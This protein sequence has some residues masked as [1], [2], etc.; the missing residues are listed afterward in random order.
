MKNPKSIS[1]IEQFTALLDTKFKIP[2]TKIRFGLDPI[3]GLIPGFGDILSY[4]ISSVL[5]FT[6]IRH[7]ASGKVAIKMIFNLILDTVI[8]AIPI[9]GTIFDVYYKANTRN[10]ELL[11]SYYKEGKNS[12]SGKEIFIITG[13]IMLAIFLLIMYLIYL[14]I[15]GIA[16]LF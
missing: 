8:G 1:G 6:M 13:I 15:S 14:L 4:G 11:K 2:G 12:G 7:G 3:L 16:G 9:L 5:I 10:L